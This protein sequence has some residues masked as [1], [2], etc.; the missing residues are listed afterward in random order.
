MS[1]PLSPPIDP[2]A[3]S[4]ERRGPLFRICIGACVIVALATRW[5]FLGYESLWFDEG[6]T[7]WLISHPAGEMLR[8]MRADT[9]APLYF[10]LLRGWTL[11]FGDDAAAMRSMSALLVTLA[12]VPWAIL[13]RRTLN[14][15]S[16]LLAAS[17][18]VSY[19]FMATQYAREVRPYAL[20]ALLTLTALA[21]V[22]AAVSRSRSSW[23]A[24]LGFA[25]CVTGGMYTHN[26][27][28]FYAVALAIA[29][30]A[31][32]RSSCP[33]PSCCTCRGSRRCASRRAGSATTSGRRGLTRR[34]GAS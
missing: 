25:F 32:W 3:Q 6:W 5:L 12:L 26:V 13:A 14:S 18:L 11:L 8:L 22:P 17:A 1:Q 30:S 24:M 15:T 4:R 20:L 27:M 16:G 10:Y 9:V 7:W 28:G 33:S 23:G 31:T 34:R 2:V 29:C 19:S 21:C